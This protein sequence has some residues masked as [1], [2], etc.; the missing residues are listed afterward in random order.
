MCVRLCVC[1][2]AHETKQNRAAQL[3]SRGPSVTHS[4]SLSLRRSPQT[5]AVCEWRRAMNDTESLGLLPGVYAPISLVMSTRET[6]PVSPEPAHRMAAQC[7]KQKIKPTRIIHKQ[8]SKKAHKIT[9]SPNWKQARA[10][11]TKTNRKKKRHIF[12]ARPAIS[13]RAAPGRSQN[14]SDPMRHTPWDSPKFSMRRTPEATRSLL[15]HQ[16]HWPNIAHVHGLS[17]VAIL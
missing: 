4:V 3:A 10:A 1:V 2:C 5:R 11:N 15:V 8:A 14:L 17:S 6:M 16:L 7:K 13:T 12:G 9:V